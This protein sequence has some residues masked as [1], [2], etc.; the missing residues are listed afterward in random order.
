MYSTETVTP[1][2]LVPWLAG[3][4]PLSYSPENPP[5]NLDLFHYSNVFASIYSSSQLKDHFF[6][7]VGFGSRH[8]LQYLE[9]YEAVRK[10]TAKQ[11]Y[12]SFGKRTVDS[13]TAPLAVYEWNYFSKRFVFI[14][15]GSIFD[16]NANN[17]PEVYEGYLNLY[18]GI[19]HNDVFEYVDLGVLSERNQEVLEHYFELQ[20]IAFSDSALSFSLAHRSVIRAETDLL[21]LREFDFYDFCAKSGFFKRGVLARTLREFSDMCFTLDRDQA[22]KKFGPS[23]VKVRTPISNLRITSFF[24]GEKEV[25]LIDS[26]RM[27]ILDSYS[28]KP[29]KWTWKNYLK[30]VKLSNSIRRRKLLDIELGR[31]V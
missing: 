20:E 18:R 11:I 25:R 26:R 5:K 9:F 13:F 10:G 14:Q 1:M 28:C 29:I 21:N 2:G 7:G 22:S 6:G 24:T 27:K 23:Y 12:F 3:S 17:H 31:K 19:R 16:V 15:H 8:G 30:R 4:G